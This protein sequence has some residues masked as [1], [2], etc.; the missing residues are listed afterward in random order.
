MR[1]RRRS[2]RIE[3][4][5]DGV[6]QFQQ[7]KDTT[8]CLIRNI[9]E[10]CKGVMIITTSDPRVCANEDVNLSIFIPAERS[11]VKCTGRIAWYSSADKETF[12]GLTVYKAGI[13]IT[14]ISRL[15][16]R[17]LELFVARKKAFFGDGIQGGNKMD[18]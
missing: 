14:E 15:D 10:D 16:R 17:R 13:F 18:S 9:S 8:E 6:I 7:T 1:G 4:D 3:I 12:Q 5:L 2:Q 11:P